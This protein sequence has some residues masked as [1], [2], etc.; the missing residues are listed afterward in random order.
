VQRI[1]IMPKKFYYYLLLAAVILFFSSN[2]MQ[3]QY[4]VY[5]GPSYVAINGGYSLPNS[6]FGKMKDNL[7]YGT[8]VKPGMN[9]GVEGA[10]FY[11][12]NIGFGMLVNVH[13][14]AIDLEQIEQEYLSFYTDYSQAKADVK[15]F[16][17]IAPMMGFFADLPVS[18]QFSITFKLLSGFYIARKPEGKVVL[19]GPVPNTYDEK[20]AIATNFAIYNSAG[21]RYSPLYHWSLHLNAEF[22]SSTFNFE[23]EN[24]GKDVI[25]KQLVR[26]ILFTAAIAY[27]F[28]PR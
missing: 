1:A 13:Y 22:V 20:F 19:S 16:V 10:Y 11:S 5:K 23:F 4:Y 28:N 6:N 9:L 12:E 25:Q 3:A 26:S 7:N 27:R 17:T 24:E 14:H 18:D 2:I 21:I 15:P 8:F